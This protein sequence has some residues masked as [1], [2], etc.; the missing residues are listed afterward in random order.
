MPDPR[1]VPSMYTLIAGAAT[2]AG[3]GIGDQGDGRRPERGFADADPHAQQRTAAPNER[4]RPLSAV[5]SA[6][7]HRADGHDGAPAARDRRAGRS[8]RRAPS[9]RRRNCSPMSSETC[10][11]RHA[12]V[13]LIGSTS[14]DRICRSTKPLTL[15]SV[16]TAT[17]YHDVPPRACRVV[18]AAPDARRAGRGNRGIRHARKHGTGAR[19]WEIACMTSRHSLPARCARCS[20]ARPARPGGGGDAA[21]RWPDTDTDP[22][23]D[24]ATDPRADAM[25]VLVDAEQ[26]LAARFGVPRRIAFTGGRLALRAAIAEVAPAPGAVLPLLRTSRGAPA[27]PDGTVGSVSHKRRLAVAVAAAPQ[28]RRAHARRGSRGDARRARPRA[29]GSRTAHPHRARAPR[30]A[31]RCNR[32]IRSPIAWPYDSASRS[33]RR[34]TRPSIRTCSATCDSRRSRCFRSDAGATTVRLAAARS[35]P[36]GRSPCTRGGHARETPARHGLGDAPVRLTSK[37]REPQSATRSVGDADQLH[38][39]HQRRV[40]RNAARDPA[41]P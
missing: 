13:A 37:R 31:R 19:R 32:P 1:K 17:T 24:P 29:P 9:R 4:A 26:E 20:S 21:R 30:A 25:P 8:A 7:E 35:L 14:S 18:I 34:S 36:A 3:K 39:E 10:V 41:R 5:I 12:E 40:G 6:P 2:L 27:V 38:F 11:S 15:A 33:R 28:R 22:A 23:T 16:S